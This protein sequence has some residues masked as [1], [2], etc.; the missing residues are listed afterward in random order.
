[1][2]IASVDPVNVVYEKQAAYYAMVLME[3]VLSSEEN[4]LVLLHCGLGEEPS[5]M[6]FY[7]LAKF[8]HTTESAAKNSFRNA[9]EKT[10]S[11]IPGSMLENW[12]LSYR[13][14]YRPD[15]KLKIQIEIKK[16]IPNL[17]VS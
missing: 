15:R 13:T 1:M 17:K 12:I 3:E 2:F 11:A 14:V 4:K 8:F 9:I 16:E 10:R 5:P 7:K 6:S